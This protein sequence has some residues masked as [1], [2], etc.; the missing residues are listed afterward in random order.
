MKV[1]FV[2]GIVG[3]ILLTILNTLLLVGVHK[4]KK[5]L[6]SIWLVAYVVVFVLNVLL[7]VFSF[8]Q[9]YANPYSQVGVVISIGLIMYFLLVVRSY[10]QS[11]ADGHSRQQNAANVYHTENSNIKRIPLA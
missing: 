9:F 10:H 2:S 8:F 1:A 6:V 7:L 4:E 5:S 3:G 11:L